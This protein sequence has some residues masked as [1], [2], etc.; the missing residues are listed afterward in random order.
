[1]SR[2][3]QMAAIRLAFA[4]DDNIPSTSLRRKALGKSAKLVNPQPLAMQHEA[5]SLLQHYA[6]HGCPVDCGDDWSREHI[7]A[8]LRRGPHISA[9]APEA[10]SYFQEEVK[11][12]IAGG[13]ATI[14]RYGDIKR[15]LPRRL[16]ISPVALIPHKSRSFRTILDLSFQLRYKGRL[17]PSV[18]S[19]TKKLAPAEAMVQLG[20]CFKRLVA[21][22]ADNVDPNNPFVFAKLD[23]KDGFW[24]MSVSKEDAWNFCYV[25]PSSEVI[26]NIDDVHLVVPTCLQMGWCESPPFF[27]AASE[28]AR[29]VIASLLAE[30]SLAHHDMEDKMLDGA[31]LRLTAAAT[32]TNLV[33]VFVDDF[34][35]ATNNS[36]EDHLRHFSRAM[37]TGVHSIFPP[38]HVSGH[39][40]ED[41][42]SQKKLRQGE[43][44][45]E[46]TKEILG[47][48]VDGAQ[49]TIQLPPE[50]CHKIVRLIKKLTKQNY[51]SLR[52][53]QELAGKLQHASFGI[54]GGKGLFSPIYRALQGTPA[55]IQI[56]PA[57]REALR[58]WRT[59]VQALAT[60]PTPVQ[61]LVPA[62]PQILQYTDA[63]KW[64]A[65]GVILPGV[66]D[67]QPIVWRYKWP[68]DITAAL[69]SSDNKS[70]RLTI[71]DLELAGLVLGWL[72]LEQTDMPLRFRHIGMFCDNTSAV[73]WAF[74]G[75]CSTSI[76]AAKLLR[77]LA[78]R[79]RTRQASSL[80]P[81][82]IAGEH[83]KMADTA[84]RAFKE[85][86][87]FQASDDLLTYFSSTFPLQTGSWQEC[88]CHPK[89]A[90]RVIS[91]L[92]SEPQQMESL[93]KL[94]KLKKNTGANG[95]NTA[96]TAASTTHTLTT[97]PPS[98]KPSSS[99]DLQPGSARGHTATEIRSVFR[100]FQVLSRPSPR[101]SSW[102]ANTV[103]STKRR[104]NTF[105]PS[106][107]AS[108]VSAAKT[109]PRS[110]N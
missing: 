66:E 81:V 82:S 62:H 6:E 5:A 51:T 34:I 101:P 73:A 50:K 4:N 107:D 43:G 86:E 24:R 45:W 68:P 8:L 38:P 55:S 80:L 31:Q 77:L 87:Y 56:T 29:D 21:T 102:T 78:V 64:G 99:T 10:I 84:S 76:P 90:S 26:E 22:L 103:P 19:A 105:F 74:K 48:I 60:R 42:V 28:T 7:E 79:Q 71:N 18:N 37:L 61:L 110:L 27:C 106:A 95:A 54:P 96:G 47:W 11:A 97:S 40:G 94:P 53:F 46:V 69:V 23:I 3:E 39:S 72:V 14:V 13:Y 15:N 93:T 20:N 30:A 36:T 109:P 59:F 104:E 2:E 100:Q 52:R 58:D 98:K 41:P 9:H 1:M 67:T 75:H 57:L 92:R 16:K 108:K 91:C 63:C 85:G 44:T 32:F 33:E 83:N 17:L 70:G 89:Y 65:G 49:F 12:K 25:M 88:V 35:A